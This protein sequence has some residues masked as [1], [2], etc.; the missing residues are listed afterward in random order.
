MGLGKKTKSQIEV[1]IKKAMPN[2]FG[3]AFNISYINSTSTNKIL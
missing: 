3:M 1:K 2:I